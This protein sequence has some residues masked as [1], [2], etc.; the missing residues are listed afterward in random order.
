MENVQ[1]HPDLFLPLLWQLNQRVKQDFIHHHYKAFP[2]VGETLVCVLF[3]SVSTPC[4]IPISS[5]CV[6]SGGPHCTVCVALASDR[7]ASLSSWTAS[8]STP[9]CG[10]GPLAR[11]IDTS[12]HPCRIK[13]RSLQSGQDNKKK[14]T[15]RNAL[16]GEGRR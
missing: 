1:I 4:V 15:R 10:D 7:Q 13:R 2:S 12:A 14:D 8:G 9:G 3:P 11:T 6:D 5:V 16:G